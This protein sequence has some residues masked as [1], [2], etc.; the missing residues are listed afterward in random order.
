MKIRDKSSYSGNRSPDKTAK[1]S[2]RLQQIMRERNIRQAE[3]ARATGISR[4]AISNYV[5]GRYE[6]KSD[7][8]QKLA[9]VLNC[10][11]KWL[12][13]YDVPMEKSINP[14]DDVEN[15]YELEVRNIFDTLH[16]DDQIYVRDWLKTFARNPEKTKSSPDQWNLTEGE[17]VMIDIFRL[18]PEDQQQVFLEMGRVYANSLK[19]G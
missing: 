4:G 17:S 12:G 5:L 8:L 7:I 15:P 13:G 3:L 16:I 14:F 6:P 11:E 19:K 2:E 18:I 10:S 9:N 1:T